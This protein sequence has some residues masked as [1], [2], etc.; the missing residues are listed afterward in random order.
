MA[1]AD[2]EWDDTDNN[3]VKECRDRASPRLISLLYIK[4]SVDQC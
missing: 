3:K 2:K 1:K 4:I